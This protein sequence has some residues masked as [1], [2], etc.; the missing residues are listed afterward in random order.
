MISILNVPEL[1][2]DWKVTVKFPFEGFGYTSI[3]FSLTCG[4]SIKE[5]ADEG[6]PDANVSAK[7]FVDPVIPHAVAFT[8]RLPE[9]KVEP[10]ETVTV[11]V[12]CPDTTVA[13]EG[14]IH[15]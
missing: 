11:F 10:I 15:V 8:P 7:F 2:A 14:G 3:R 9:L 13:P 4:F 5:V 12:P 1:M 6:Q